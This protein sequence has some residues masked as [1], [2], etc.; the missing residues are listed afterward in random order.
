[1]TLT[2]RHVRHALDVFI[3]GS[4]DGTGLSAWVEAVQGREDIGLDTGNRDR[5]ADALFKLSTP[6]LFGPII[7]LVDEIRERLS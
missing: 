7:D 2:V 3:E 5:L 1:M 4:I 6:E